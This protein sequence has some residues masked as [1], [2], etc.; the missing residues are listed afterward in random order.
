MCVRL[1]LCACARV[2][3]CVRMRIC[4]S[5]LRVSSRKLHTSPPLQPEGQHR[6]PEL[7]SPQKVE[8]WR[9]PSELLLARALEAGG[10]ALLGNYMVLCQAELLYQSLPLRHELCFSVPC[11][12]LCSTTIF[13]IP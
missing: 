10:L 13:T 1:C 9:W 5:C 11:V 8:L 2:Y 3:A 7:S 4:M 6:G 12:L